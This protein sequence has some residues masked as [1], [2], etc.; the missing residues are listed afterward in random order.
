MQTYSPT[1]LI[2]DKTYEDWIVKWWNHDFAYIA[3]VHLL[4][5]DYDGDMPSIIEFSK[6]IEALL[7]SPINYIAMDDGVES[8]GAMLKRAIEEI[9]IVDPAKITTK[10][11]GEEI[12]HL[13]TRVRTKLFQTV[14]GWGISDGYWIFLKGPFRKGP[15]NITTFGTCKS[16]QIQLSRSTDLLV[17]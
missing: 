2:F 5:A 10:F 11:D 4:V 9:D 8:Y 3:P 6:S 1:E 15:H 14:N 7:L 13:A 16:G 17:V 12:G